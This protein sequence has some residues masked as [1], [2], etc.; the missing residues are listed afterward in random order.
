MAFSLIPGLRKGPLNPSKI[1]LWSLESEL[2]EA[3]ALSHPRDP[4]GG[5]ITS[6]HI[7]LS[8]TLSRTCHRFYYYLTNY[9]IGYASWN[10]LG[11]RLSNFH[12]CATPSLYCV[13]CWSVIHQHPVCTVL[14]IKALK[15]RAW[16][17]IC[18]RGLKKSVAFIYFSFMTLKQMLRFSKHLWV[19]LAAQTGVM[20]DIMLDYFSFL[21]DLYI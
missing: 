13:S 9:V 15:A 14:A 3:A 12:M 1:T 19:W 21:G 17:Q 7:S 8:K 20:A 11:K 2:G 5:A 4:L 6:K 10:T 16:L 18:M